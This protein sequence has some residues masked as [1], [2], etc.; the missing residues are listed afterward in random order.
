[1][2]NIATVQ[3]AADRQRNVRQQADNNRRLRADPGKAWSDLRSADHPS[4]TVP[5]RTASDHLGHSRQGEATS[6]GLKDR[7]S[8]WSHA[9][10]EME[11]TQGE[12][13]CAG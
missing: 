9:V 7:S 1:M 10:Y 12:A 6:A 2:L 11:P 5:R 4:R 8:V 13:S 3:M